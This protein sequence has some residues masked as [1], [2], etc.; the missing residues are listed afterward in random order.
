MAKA[1][2]G[3]AP[4]GRGR[5]RESVGRAPSVPTTSRQYPPSESLSTTPAPGSSETQVPSGRTTAVVRPSR[6]VRSRSSSPVARATTVPV[7]VAPAAAPRPIT[8]QSGGNAAKSTSFSDPEIR[9]IA[10]PVGVCTGS[11]TT[12]AG[13]LFGSGSRMTLAR[14][15]CRQ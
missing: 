12:S 1:P 5:A 9:L 13:A 7:Y 14:Y 8:V 4:D 11:I 2:G 6:S 15:G 10:V 3:G